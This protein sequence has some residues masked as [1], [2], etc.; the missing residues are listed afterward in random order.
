MNPRD[1]ELFITLAKQQDATTT[2][3]HMICSEGSRSLEQDR[4]RAGKK[5][6]PSINS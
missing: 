4:N 6:L 1:G 2:F 3:S 5:S